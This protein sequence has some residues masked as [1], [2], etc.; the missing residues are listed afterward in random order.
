MWP[1][2]ELWRSLRSRWAAQGPFI[3]DH[4]PY[5]HTTGRGA[6]ITAKLFRSLSADLITE[7]ASTIL[8]L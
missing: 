8:S 3:E 7:V 2:C 4:H 6:I 1:T 5:P